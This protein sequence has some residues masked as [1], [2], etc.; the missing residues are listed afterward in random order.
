ME[1]IVI[2]PKTLLEEKQ[3]HLPE[4]I[5]ISGNRIV[6]SAKASHILS[7]K[8]KTRF[9]ILIRNNK[10]FYR[11]SAPS[12]D[13]FTAYKLGNGPLLRLASNVNGLPEMLDG[14]KKLNKKFEVEPRP[15][16]KGGVRFDFLLGNLHEGGLWE[17]I[18][19]PM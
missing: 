2:S 7:L 6:F 4:K 18:A 17:L 1:A 8:E 15:S 5:T 10:L 9:T 19:I 13:A 3:K 11:E 12:E 14:I 16:N